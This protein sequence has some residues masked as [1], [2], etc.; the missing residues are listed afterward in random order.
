MKYNTPYG[1]QVNTLKLVKQL[2]VHHVRDD[3]YPMNKLQGSIWT[4]FELEG[5]K[6]DVLLQKPTVQPA[7]NAIA[8]LETFH[9]SISSIESPNEFDGDNPDWIAQLKTYQE[10]LWNT[11]KALPD[12]AKIPVLG[13]TFK[14]DT[15]FQSVGDISSWLSGVAIHPYAGGGVPDRNLTR[16]ISLTYHNAPPGTPIY[17]TEAGYHNALNADKGQPPVP[18]AVAGSYIPRLF[19]DF[20][21]QGIARTFVYELYDEFPDDGLTNA[22]RHFGLVR[23]DG[24]LKPAYI[25]LRN[26]LTYVAD[27][28]ES[29]NMGQP[30]AWINN[31]QLSHGSVTDGSVR[32]LRLLRFDGS[33]DLVVW[34]NVQIWDYMKRELLPVKAGTVQIAVKNGSRVSLFQASTGIEAQEL[35]SIGVE[36]DNNLFSVQLGADAVV[37]RC[38]RP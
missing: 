22:E 19:L 16:N 36:G 29:K 14:R 33:V 17:V 35:P 6:I 8:A 5:I 34:R 1:D 31:I 32:S 9:T 12:L 26:L 10:D 18:E 37:L 13:P 4:L 38:T 2:G 7:T 11:T 21:A 25:Q 28:L 15:S 20:F 24:S 23:F 27:P 3:Q 30:P